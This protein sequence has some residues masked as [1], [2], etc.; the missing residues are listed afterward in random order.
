MLQA[1]AGTLAAPP[2]PARLELT[3]DP[4][5]VGPNEMHVFDRADG[6]R[7]ARTKELTVTALLPER[8][9]EPMELDAA[10]AGPGHRVMSGA[11]FGVEGEWTVGDRRPRVRFRPDP[12]EV[13]GSDPVRVGNG[14]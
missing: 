7:Y 6:S 14:L 1:P 13:G 5:R 12:E 8:G 10:K 2:R 9:I 3:A 4:A 11:A